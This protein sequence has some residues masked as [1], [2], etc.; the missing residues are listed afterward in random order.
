M[1][2]RAYLCVIVP[3]GNTA[4]FE[5]KPQQWRAVRNTVS[6]LTGPKFEPHLLS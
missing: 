3:A 1:S 2:L 6:D 5:E 4:P